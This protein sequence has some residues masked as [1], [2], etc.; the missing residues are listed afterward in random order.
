MSD[1]EC[2]NKNMKEKD[3]IKLSMGRFK[4]MEEIERT[5]SRAETVAMR[6]K[7]LN[8]IRRMA[9]ELGITPREDKDIA[10]VR[11]RWVRLKKEYAVK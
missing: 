4:I 11:E 1:L 3:L 8:A 10:I 6:W 2:Y 7:K 5:E 9:Q